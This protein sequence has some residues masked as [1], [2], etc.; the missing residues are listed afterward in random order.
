MT[1][2]QV[3]QAM[4]EMVRGRLQSGH[5][6]LAISMISYRFINIM[7]IK[8]NKVKYIIHFIYYWRLIPG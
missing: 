7:N 4:R 1:K 5:V 6:T 2:L 3:G 8:L